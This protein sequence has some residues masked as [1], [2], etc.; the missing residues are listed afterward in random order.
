MT[1]TALPEY[2][3]RDFLTTVHGTPREGAVILHLDDIPWWILPRHPLTHDRVYEGGDAVE[4]GA[5]WKVLDGEPRVVQPSVPIEKV[6]L[7]FDVSNFP[8]GEAPVRFN[9]S[10][11]GFSDGEV[12]P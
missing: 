2:A 8:Q 4:H 10:I 12:V 5:I 3:T 1:T 6:G 9:L 7:S 11:W